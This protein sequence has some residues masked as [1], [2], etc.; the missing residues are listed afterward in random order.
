MSSTMNPDDDDDAEFA[1]EFDFDAMEINPDADERLR[2][3]RDDAKPET[4]GHRCLAPIHAPGLPF[5]MIP[6]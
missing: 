4:S 1:L 5:S 2:F 3:M 6:F